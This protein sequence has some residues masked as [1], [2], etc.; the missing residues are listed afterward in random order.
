MAVTV[1]TN[2]STKKTQQVY[3]N[4][5][6]RCESLLASQTASVISFHPHGQVCTCLNGVLNEYLRASAR[7]LRRLCDP[8]LASR[9]EAENPLGTTQA[10]HYWGE[11]TSSASIFGST[12]AS[13]PPTPWMLQVQSEIRPDIGLNTNLRPTALKSVGL[14]FRVIGFRA[15]GSG[16]AGLP[17]AG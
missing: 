7:A 6:F 14:G 10:F 4:S 2:T 8:K 3:R 9:S 1:G 12:L 5:D 17:R 15:R 13:S 16:P 11:R